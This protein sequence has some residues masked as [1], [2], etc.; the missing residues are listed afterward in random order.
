MMAFSSMA[1]AQDPAK[2]TP[3]M[4]AKEWADLEKTLWDV[5]QQWLCSGGATRYHQDYKEC[6]EFRNQ[7]WADQF[8]EVSIKGEVQTKSEMIARQRAVHP[9]KGVGPHP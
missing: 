5:D 8:F 6:I 1:Y 7:F 4:T 3:K 2:A 9:S